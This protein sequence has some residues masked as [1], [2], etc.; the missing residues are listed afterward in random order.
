LAIKLASNIR[1]VVSFDRG[2]HEIDFGQIWYQ[3][4]DIEKLE[5]HGRV[6]SVAD[7]HKQNNKLNKRLGA[8]FF[9]EYV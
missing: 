2:N 5:Q 1:P 9:F 7:A 6:I 3:K 4:A 8:V